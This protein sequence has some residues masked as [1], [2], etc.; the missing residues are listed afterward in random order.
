MGMKWFRLLR[1]IE[2]R[3]RRMIVGLLNH[4]SKNNCEQRTRTRG[5]NPRRLYLDA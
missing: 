5:L 4:R 1:Q 3:M 2:G